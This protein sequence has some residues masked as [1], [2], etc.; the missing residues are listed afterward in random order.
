M[1]AVPGPVVGR[2][3]IDCGIE[4]CLERD[5]GGLISF[6]HAASGSPISIKFG[7]PLFVDG[8]ATQDKR[9]TNDEFNVGERFASS[10]NQ[11]T[12]VALINF[13]GAVI[14]ST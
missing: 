4:H 3:V 9:F 14:F 6:G 11:G 13:R 2:G 1:H 8:A 7:K 10:I 12:I 5:K